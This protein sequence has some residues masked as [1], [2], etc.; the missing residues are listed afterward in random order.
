MYRDATYE[1]ELGEESD[2]EDYIPDM[3]DLPDLGFASDEA[4]SDDPQQPRV[5]DTP[6][7]KQK[8]HEE[9]NMVMDL[10]KSHRRASLDS[11]KWQRSKRK[12]ARKAAS[13][14][15]GEG[16]FGS[17]DEKTSDDSSDNDEGDMK[18]W[19]GQT[20]RKAARRKEQ[21]SRAR[22]KRRAKSPTKNPRKYRVRNKMASL[23]TQEVISAAVSR[24]K[25][26]KKKAC[27]WKLN[28]V[29]D[30]GHDE[31]TEHRTQT[32]EWTASGEREYIKDLLRSQLAHNVDFVRGCIFFQQK[33]MCS[34]CFEDYHGIGVNHHII[35]T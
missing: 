9:L 27:T 1:Y 33:Q 7:K 22:K 6:E 29:V 21:K 26:C 11:T 19:N 32:A 14:M 13:N 10:V 2:D 8:A 12:R 20:Y 18:G 17:G 31:V 25:R 3:D 4:S 30:G 5:L 23:V 34:A 28:N 16:A 35:C 15:F 24:I